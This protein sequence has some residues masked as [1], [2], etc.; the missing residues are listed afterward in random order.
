MSER[1]M[2]SFDLGV[3]QA[4]GFGCELFFWEQLT[5]IATSTDSDAKY[6]LHT[7]RNCCGVQLRS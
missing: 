4:F 7:V 2:F 5:V 6:P 3:I 1:D